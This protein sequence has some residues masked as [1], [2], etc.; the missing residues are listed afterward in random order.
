MRQQHFRHAQE[1]ITG[2]ARRNYGKRMAKRHLI[3]H[4]L[5]TILKKDNT[6]LLLHPPLTANHLHNKYNSISYSTSATA[7]PI[8]FDIYFFLK[9]LHLF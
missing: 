5:S 1:K 9:D 4:R 6:C 2:G 8:G 3:T 7:H